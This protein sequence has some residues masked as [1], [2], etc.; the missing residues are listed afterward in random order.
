MER[1]RGSRRCA[2]SGEERSFFVRIREWFDERIC[3][4]FAD[5]M[6][7][8][9][10]EASG[11]MVW[12]D[13]EP[14]WRT[15]L[16]RVLLWL[17]A[18]ALVLVLF[19]GI[20]LYLFIG[21][22]ATDLTAKALDN[23]RSG[24]LPMAWLQIRSAEGLR[25][26][27]E[28]IRRVKT[29][30]QSRMGS[31][32]ALLQWEKLAAGGG[33]TPDEAEERARLAALAGSD[34]QF[35]EA[36][37]AVELNGN[38]V[39]VAGFRTS[40][41]LRRGDLESSVEQARLAAAS[42]DPARQMN[43]LRVLLMRYGPSL[44]KRGGATPGSA[45]ALQEIIALVDGMQGTPQGHQALAMTLGVIPLPADKAREWASAALKDLSP[46]NPALLP[47]AQ[48]MIAGRQGT[49]REFFAKLSP[50]FEDA[51]LESQ[52]RFAQW[53][54]RYGMWD[55]ILQIVT[56]E[57]AE[58]GTAAFQARGRALAG[59]GQWQEL[60]D[61][62]G[63]APR[64]FESLRL[65]FRG[66]ALKNLDKRNL[67]QKT[68]A[69]AIYAAARDGTMGPTLEA[70]DASGES[71]VADPILIKLCANPTMTDV[72]FRLARDRFARRGQLASL[73]EAWSTASAAA[74]ELPAVLDYGRRT[75]LLEGRD[76]SLKETA[77]AMAAAPADAQMRFTHALNLLKADRAADA[78]GVFH[79]M[80]VMAAELPPGDKAV[81]IAILEANGMRGQAE[82]LRRSLNPGLLRKGEFALIV[83]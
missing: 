46:D 41:L 50:I 29:F 43:L 79:D 45:A 51:P 81:A 68:W 83:R 70:A 26:G 4:P 33:L 36:V 73:A 52:I 76:V 27:R 38:A 25:P 69:D 78:F 7:C 23:A 62:T 34:R 14:A 17:P 77:A 66:I 11:P 13:F 82:I 63:S 80:D 20:T 8:W 56:P 54:G 48:I 75:D 9:W 1:V 19:V 10:K 37:A 53:L 55:D 16:Q 32:E 18:A 44:K 47:S 67:A 72:M 3:G 59:K 24:N 15:V 57:K 61:M 58:R 42:G 60:F 71:A 22:R 31:R 30:V 74:P 40:R 35:E 39:A 65:V 6:R 12:D 49:P 5:L 2:E 21:W 64:I 28:K